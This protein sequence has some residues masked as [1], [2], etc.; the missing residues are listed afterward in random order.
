MIYFVCVY[1]YI[2]IVI[3]F[4]GEKARLKRVDTVGL[5]FE[6]H[7]KEENIRRLRGLE[8]FMLRMLE[9]PHQYVQNFFHFAHLKLIFSIS[10][11]YFYKTLISVCLLYTFIQIKYSFF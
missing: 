4:R 10:Y 8:L 3:C 7:K 6:R 9:H 11:T 1:I 5:T 2:Y